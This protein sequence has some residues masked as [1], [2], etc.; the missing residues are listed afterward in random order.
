[1]RINNRIKIN[2]SKLI[3]EGTYAK[4]YEGYDKMKREKIA[5]KEIKGDQM[6]ENEIEIIKELR[7][8]RNDNIVKYYEI[9]RKEDKIYITM[10][11]CQDGDLQKIIKKI[12]NENEIRT[13]FKQILSGI[14]H[15]RKMNI[16]H[17]DIK[18]KNIL[19]KNGVLKIADF[20]LAKKMKKKE[21]S[22]TVCGS[23]LYMAPEIIKKK[24]YNNKSDIWSLGIILYEMIFKKNPFQECKNINELTN[25][26]NNKKIDI[27][28]NENININMECIKLIKKMLQKE[29][30]KRIEWNELFNDKWIKDIEYD[31]IE[32]YIKEYNAQDYEYPYSKI[33]IEDYDIIEEYIKCEEKED[34]LQFDME[35]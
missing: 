30:E 12:K 14:L 27:E 23:P 21:M 28:E 24:E 18:P 33:Y 15:L 29:E 16:V 7:K 17:R 19:I 2:K 13:Y 20:G 6:A 4:V 10:E 25:K 22:D 32:N 1:M 35:I 5:I 11:Y 8:S 31:V 34:E 3:G 26:I 9:I